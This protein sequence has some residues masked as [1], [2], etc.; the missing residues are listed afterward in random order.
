MREVDSLRDYER[1]RDRITQLPKEK[2]D[3]P[4]QEG[5]VNIRTRRVRL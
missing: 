4:D 1:P 5:D 2:G 3:H